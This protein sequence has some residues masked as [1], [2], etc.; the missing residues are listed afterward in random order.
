MDKKEK[1]AMLKKVREKLSQQKGSRRDPWMFRVPAVKPNE[2][3]KYRFVV[4]PGLAK[5]SKCV[6][7]VVSKGMDDMFCVSGGQ[8]WINQ[9]PYGC[10]RQFDGQE[11]PWCNL[12]FNLLN[13]CDLEE[14]R[15]KISRMYLP[16]S[17]FAVNIFFPAFPMNPSDLHN[18]VMWYTMPKTIY[19]KMEDCLMRE[20][21]GDDPEHDPK[22]FGMFYDP[23]DCL[24]FQLEVTHKGG[25][26][27]YESSKFLLN[28]QSIGETK[29][30]IQAILDQRHDLWSKFPQ[31]DA[32]ELH[33]LLEKLYGG[34]NPP[35]VD[36]PEAKSNPKPKPDPTPKEKNDDENV[37][38][39]SK[40]N[41]AE[42]KPEPLPKKASTQT[43]EP[44]PE[45]DDARLAEDDP[46]LQALLEEVQ[47]DD[48]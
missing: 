42:G 1:E 32:T 29:E 9:R 15:K 33:K 24:V 45:V 13:E 23:E 2:S 27:N 14:E 36:R 25:Y 7:G 11:C 21:A 48:A 6:D 3:L 46:E 31:R 41:V 5:G 12:G 16:R 40:K 4:L 39:K 8:H 18:K 44:E 37:L 34:T 43:P 20:N 38:P 47:G 30:E 28:R 19:D 26:N 35:P 17:V 22:P 10:P